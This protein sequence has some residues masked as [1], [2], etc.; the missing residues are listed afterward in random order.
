LSVTILEQVQ[1]RLHGEHPGADFEAQARDGVVEQPVPGCLP[2]HGLLLEKLLDAILKL[3][4]FLLADVLDPRP[5]MTERRIRH[6]AFQHGV[7]D[8]VEL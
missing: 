7:V 8:L 4:G 2:G 1:G 3:I 6:G 5:I